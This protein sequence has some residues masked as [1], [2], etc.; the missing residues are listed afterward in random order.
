MCKLTGEFDASTLSPNDFELVKDVNTIHEGRG[1]FLFTPESNAKYFVK[2]ICPAGIRNLLP[3][4]SEAPQTSGAVITC[5]IGSVSR[6]NKNIG[7][8]VRTTEAGSYRVVLSKRDIEVASSMIEVEEA[9]KPYEVTF[10]PPSFLGDGVLR[11]TLFSP[12]DIPLSER[13]VFR[14]P[15]QHIKVDIEADKKAYSPGDWVNLTIK[16]SDKFDKPVVSFVSLTV[17]DDSVLEMVERRKQVPRLRE[18]AMLESEVKHL[19]DAP[20]Y[21]R[22]DDKSFVA[23]D[24]LLGTQ[25]WRRFVYFNTPLEVEEFLRKNKGQ[26]IVA[27]STENTIEDSSDESYTPLDYHFDET[28]Q[29]H[30]KEK[31]KKEVSRSSSVSK[32]GRGGMTKT[33]S[34]TP[35]PPSGGILLA[36]RG[37]GAPPV[38]PR[39][40]GPPPAAPRSTGPPPALKSHDKSK[41]K[42]SGKNGDFLSS[43]LSKSFFSSPRRRISTE[44][45]QPQAKQYIPFTMRVFVHERKESIYDEVDLRDD[46]LETIYWDAGNVVRG[47]RVYQF[48]LPDNITSFKAMADAFNSS[49]SFG[50][51]DKLIKSIVPFAVEPKLPKE[52]SIND[53]IDI[54]I[55][56]MNNTE[57]DISD[58]QVELVASR[59]LTESEYSEAHVHVK[60]RSK[61]RRLASLVVGP[62]TGTFDV[63]INASSAVA[64]QKDS[65]SRKLKV[66]SSGFPYWFHYPGLLQPNRELSWKINIPKDFV[67]NSL[68]TKVNF[69]ANTGTSMMETVKGLVAI[70][71][72]CFEQIGGTLF[73]GIMAKQYFLSHPGA[74]PVVLTRAER[75]LTVGYEKLVKFE[76]ATGGFDWFG[77]QPGNEVLSAYSL[78]LFKEFSKVSD[79]VD[80][81]LV[82]RTINWLLTRRGPAGKFETKSGRNYSPPSRIA[83][84]YILWA[85]T[86]HS[87][88]G[89]EPEIEAAVKMA[90]ANTGDNYLLALVS[91][92][93]INVGRHK[94]A[95]ALMQKPAADQRTGQ[96]YGLQSIVQCY[97]RGL[98]I[99]TTALSVLAWIGTGSPQFQTNIDSAMEFIHQSRSGW[100]WDSSQSNTL[101]LMAILA[102][103]KGVPGAEPGE[104]KIS[105]YVDDLVSEAT[106]G[107]E[108]ITFPDL[109]P[110]L[111]PGE[112]TIRVLLTNANK[113]HFNLSVKLQQL[114]PDNHPECRVSLATELTGGISCIEE[115]EMTEVNVTVTNVTNEIIPMT[116]ARVRLPGGLEPRHEKLKELV[117]LGKISFYEIFKGREVALHW[118][119]L[120]PNEVI[121]IAFDVIAHVPGK[122]TGKASVAHL[123]YTREQTFFAPGIQI[124]ITPRQTRNTEP[125]QGPMESIVPWE[126]TTPSDNQDEPELNYYSGGQAINEFY[127]GFDLSAYGGSVSTG[128]F[129]GF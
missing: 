108:Q 71:H 120:K 40:T 62:K 98:H 69:M 39:S 24:L 86:S 30:C 5:P 28:Y 113:G 15:R 64:N 78:L 45:Q 47:E 48:Q 46:F 10:S 122:Y 68:A 26:Q 19:F 73:P 84:A 38:A 22:G 42:Y 77:N 37:T 44:K 74:L 1:R 3:V 83:H 16:T 79:L 21:L 11:V 9:G 59:K 95:I 111:T 123:Y 126:S 114:V 101:V 127:G 52:V 129:I 94:D 97:G 121:K 61:A 4:N 13:L 31:G 7:V 115:G 96:V 112:H 8:T 119:G 2:V 67:Q 33:G 106:V 125:T 20:V 124:Q 107:K 43:S 50:S 85:L 109:S 63:V 34:R 100:G 29:V 57:E 51:C 14:Y 70:P 104:P 6:P 35:P 91:L 17:T 18:I 89:L 72:G 32:K 56:F 87:M 23:T 80:P 41:K 75:M 58:A 82:R 105:L 55:V 60:K 90:N 27:V 81:A 36:P 65:V 53:R 54:P 25:G 99:Q 92:S 93:L 49:H 128:G 88:P 102:N 116:L 66:L 76:V 118:R 110:L 103:E 12:S 117:K